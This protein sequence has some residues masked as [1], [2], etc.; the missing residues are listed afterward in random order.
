MPSH[1][2][3]TPLIPLIQNT[4]TN[5]INL[6][7]NHAHILCGDFNRDVALIGRQNDTQITPP[8]EEDHL[9]RT[10]TTCLDL[11]YVQTNTNFSRQG[12]HN[13]TQN[14]LINGFFIKTNTNNQYT[15]TTDQT[16]RLN[17]DHLPIHLHIPPNT[18][19]AKDSITVS[20]PPPRILNPIPKDK[21]DAFHTLF[22]EQHSHQIDELTLLLE[23]DQL[24]HAQWQLACNAFTILTDK[25]FHAILA[26]YSVPPIPALPTHIA[27]QGGYLP[28][29]PQKQWKLNLSTYHLIR[30]IIY[31]IKNNPTWLTHPLITQGLN[32]YRHAHIPSPPAP[33]LPYDDWIG[34]LATI[35]KDS[36]NKA[37]K[38]TTEYTKIQI[39]KAISKYQ[40]LYDKSPKK[41]N[42]RVFKNVDTPPLDCLMD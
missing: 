2:D 27:K 1:T 32:T 13:Y 19:I 5:Q 34:T 10:F 17:S 3:D 38:I 41:I 40:Q 25:I 23:H 4:I 22:F 16:T 28:K 33:H 8:Q 37:R 24:T 39:K 6:H 36:K 20:A 42:R 12:G 35:G 21:L 11:S 26:T 9:W 31:I 7:P 14:S 29:K 18:F 15:S 30:K